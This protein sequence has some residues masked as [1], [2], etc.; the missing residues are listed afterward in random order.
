MTRCH[1]CRSPSS[2]PDAGRL[3]VL[4][5]FT[6]PANL[7]VKPKSAQVGLKWSTIPSR[8]APTRPLFCP[9]MRETR[10]NSGGLR[11]CVSG[12]R[13]SPEYG[14]M[15]SSAKYWHGSSPWGVPPQP[16]PSQP[17]WATNCPPPRS[18]I[19]HPLWCSCRGH[20][21]DLPPCA[22]SPSSPSR[23]RLQQA[24]PANLPHPRPA[25]APFAAGPPQTVRCRLS[26]TV[27][28]MRLLAYPPW[29]R[30]QN[31]HLR[32]PERMECGIAALDC[33]KN[34]WV[35]DSLARQRRLESD[36]IIPQLVEACGG[37]EYPCS[38]SP[39]G[40]ENSN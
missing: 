22:I 25:P 23:I 14:R 26:R 20:T 30:S 17:S 1:E 38:D 40:T 37:F 8:A 2:E 21:P 32:K 7:N 4:Y 34:E 11:A 12:R 39:D 16:S 29:L 35:A 6:S 5:A 24:A 9:V 13:A 18:D 15:Y 19:R 28:G 36:R 33:V 27:R 31:P 3:P 10:Q